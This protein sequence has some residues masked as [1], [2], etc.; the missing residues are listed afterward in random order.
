MAILPYIYLGYMFISLY[1]LSMFLIIYLKNRKSIF[2]YPETKKNYSI[3]FI[4]PAF[5]E[6]KTIEDTIEHIFNVGYKNIMEVIVINDCS[7]DNTLKIA[8][9]LCKKY[10]KLKILNNKKNLGKAGALNKGLKICKGELVTV[11]DADSYPS[12]HSV[13]KMVGFFDD[14]KVGAVTCPVTSRNTNKFIER[15][16]A[17]EYKMIAFTRKLLDYVEAIYV[18]PG[19]LAVYRKK[20]IVGV[21]GFDE[22]NMTEDIEVAWALTFNGWKRRMCL[23]TSV[24]S[25]VPNK[26]VSWFK[27]RRRWNVGGLQ[28]IYKY[29]KSLFDIKKGMLG[30]F[31]IPF[32]ILSTFLGLLGLSI[33]FYLL[34]RRIIS[35]FLRTR[36]SI[37]TD[38]P[39]LTAEEI[40]ITPSVLNYLGIV[41]FFFGLTLL[42]I[43][44]V[45]LK[46][47]ILRKENMFNIPFYMI[48]YMALY[49]FI[50]LTA[51][52][53]VIKGKRVWR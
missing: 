20:A 50:M 39:I 52:W 34:T 42:L 4:V 45:I 32:F 40:F 8:K 7:T 51:I 1:M 26:F 13:S 11:V 48:I 10:L 37:V 28:C 35:N 44:F 38:T 29:R 36:Y 19:P 49:P 33:F 53:H 24:S 16:Q 12:K 3:S 43:V 31:I 47:K 23:S 15:L 30:F 27:Q 46:E 22:K 6:E 41:L 21:G 2:Y 25:T 5:N 17:I 18:T 14:E 9:G